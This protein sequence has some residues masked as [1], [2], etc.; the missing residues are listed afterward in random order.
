MH[1]QRCFRNATMDFQ[2]EHARFSLPICSEHAETSLYEFMKYHYYMPPRVQCMDSYSV[3]T[4]YIEWLRVP[5]M[6]PCKSSQA[7]QTRRHSHISHHSCAACLACLGR[8]LSVFSYFTYDTC[9]ANFCFQETGNCITRMFRRMV[10]RSDRSAFSNPSPE[11]IHV[12]S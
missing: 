6:S 9:I 3:V 2:L 5:H 7:F 8:V 1:P 10:G 4:M 11:T 12:L